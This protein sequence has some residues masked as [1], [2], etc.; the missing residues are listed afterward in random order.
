ME[1]IIK[2]AIEILRLGYVCDRCLGRQFAQLLTNTSNEVRGSAL[3]R[4]VALMVDAK[5]DTFGIHPENFKGVELRWVK[6]PKTA[7]TTKCFL[8]ENSFEKIDSLVR[9]A[10]RL[11][12]NYEFWRFLVGTRPPTRLLEKEEELWERIGI[13]YCE[14]LKAELNREIGKKLELALKLEGRKVT[15]DRERPEVVLIFDLETGEIELNVNSLFIYGEYQKLKR[16][17]PQTKWKRRIYKT[18]VQEL[19]EKPILKAT[20]G[21]KALFHGAGREDITARCLGWRPFVLEIKE[22]RR[23][24]V[25]LKEMEKLINV[26]NFVKVRRLRFVDSSEVEKIKTA[27][28]LKSYRVLVKC[29]RTLTSDDLKRLQALVTIIS[30]RTPTRVLRRRSDLVRKRKVYKLKARLVGRKHIELEITTDPGLY[31]KELVTGDDGRTKPSVAEVLGCECEVK[32]LDV[33]AIH[34]KP[35]KGFRTEKKKS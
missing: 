22:P 19:I 24:K 29:G 12:K 5:R 35:I 16:G 3:R 4:T 32:E 23:R 30:Q 20:K 33:I 2:R 14:P 28:Y 31:V 18:S 17:I 26:G 34:K 7:R 15:V 27:D 21:K 13:E 11:L 25:D 8:C 9:R 10:R 1:E 6:V